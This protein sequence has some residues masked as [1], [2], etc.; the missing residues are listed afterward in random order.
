[1][2]SWMRRLCRSPLDLDIYRNAYR[3]RLIE[4]LNE[5]YPVLH[6]VL[7]DDDFATLGEEFVAAHPSV[8]RSI[9]WYGSELSDFLAAMFALCRACRF[10]R[11]SRCSNGRW[12]RFSIRQMPSRR[13]ARRSRL[14]TLPPGAI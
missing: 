11:S 8:H 1:M 4:A 7:G 13:R 2:P 14:S 3:V 9:R 5:T 12:P 6:A 10:S